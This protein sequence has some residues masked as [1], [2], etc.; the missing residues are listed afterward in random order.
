MNAEYVDI[1]FALIAKDGD[2]LYPYR[3]NQR[4]TG[5]FGF[6]VSAPSERDAFGG[7]EYLQTLEEVVSS[8]VLQGWKIRAT[9]IDK[10]NRQRHGSFSLHGNT[11]V[12]YWIANELKHLVKGAHIQPR[13]LPGR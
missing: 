2:V 5:R 10:A 3:K 9:T 8:V 13:S 11:I 4:A 6:A 12:G 1:R 7:G